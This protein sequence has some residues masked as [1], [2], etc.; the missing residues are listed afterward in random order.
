M[1][2][3]NLVFVLLFAFLK[4]GYGYTDDEPDIFLM[5]DNV[6]KDMI[7]ALHKKLEGDMDLFKSLMPDEHEPVGSE[8]KQVLQQVISNEYAY[9][10]SSLAEDDEF[11]YMLKTAAI[12]N[13]VESAFENSVGKV[14]ESYVDELMNMIDNEVQ[15]YKQKLSLEQSNNRVR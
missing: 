7:E 4:N 12:R 13:A 2:K 6:D 10:I 1:R 8:A 14:E 3:T 11:T 9:I 15:L 5:G